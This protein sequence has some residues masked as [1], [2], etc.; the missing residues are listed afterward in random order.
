VPEFTFT[1]LMRRFISEKPEAAWSADEV[2]TFLLER[3]E[4]GDLYI[5]CP[6]NEVTE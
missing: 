2:A 4:R 1:G 3:L 6:D 5:L